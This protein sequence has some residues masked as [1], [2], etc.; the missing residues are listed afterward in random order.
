MNNLEKHDVP[1][2]RCPFAVASVISTAFGILFIFID[3]IIAALNTFY[4]PCIL[5]TGAP[6]SLARIIMLSFFGLAA[7]L[8]II[9]IFRLTISGEKGKWL[10]YA[11]ISVLISTILGGVIFVALHIV[12]EIAKVR[13]EKQS[14][15]KVTSEQ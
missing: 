5:A 2:N 6:F 4:R 10:K 15:Q 3:F 13:A 11:I 1:I 9:S 7:F 8:G 14:S 12:S